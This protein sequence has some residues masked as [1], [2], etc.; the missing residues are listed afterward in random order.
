MASLTVGLT[1][2]DFQFAK[3]I[4]KG[5]PDLFEASKA[6]PLFEQAKD[7][8]ADALMKDLPLMIKNQGEGDHANLH[9]HFI[10]RAFYEES[11]ERLQWEFMG[12]LSPLTSFELLGR[13][14]VTS[15]NLKNK[16]FGILYQALSPEQK[17]TLCKTNLEV[18]GNQKDVKVM[19]VNILSDYWEI[20]FDNK[21]EMDFIITNL[22]D[23]DFPET[24]EFSSKSVGVL[25]KHSEKTINGMKKYTTLT[26]RKHSIDDWSPFETFCNDTDFVLANIDII[27]E[28]KID[29]KVCMAVFE[30][31]MTRDQ[32]PDCNFLN[33]S[34]DD[35]I[36]RYGTL[37]EARAIC[38]EHLKKILNVA[39]DM[40]FVLE[41]T[42]KDVEV[43]PQFAETMKPSHVLMQGVTMY[44]RALPYS[45]VEEKLRR[46]SK[47]ERESSPARVQAT[48]NSE[49]CSGG[50]DTCPA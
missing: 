8:R 28:I 44:A 33:T 19:N 25:D 2:A 50:G 10:G 45:Q 14:N 15:G 43:F 21:N 29:I 11:M 46:G 48:I 38:I 6:G 3:V 12:L 47:R 35:I 24:Q 39:P 5:I 49:L 40:L 13:Y 42:V 36:A 34:A 23:D 1:L 22:T 20:A 31:R 26:Q 7:V 18:R 32:S 17:L 37:E 30:V 16:F 41:A 9:L 4:E 27:K